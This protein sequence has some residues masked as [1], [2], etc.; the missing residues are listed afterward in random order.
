MPDYAFISHSIER[1][2]A[3]LTLLPSA[4]FGMGR[5]IDQ[6]LCIADGC[7]PGESEVSDSEVG[8]SPGAKK[9]LLVGTA[10]E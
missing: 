7:A 4:L 8:F 3:A 9:V 5:R 6:Y 1:R 10:G 2:L